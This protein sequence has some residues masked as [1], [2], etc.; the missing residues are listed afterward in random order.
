MAAGVAPAAANLANRRPAP[1][2]QPN[3]GPRRALAVPSRRPARPTIRDVAD[4]AGVALGSASRVINGHA[5]VGEDVRDKVLRAIAQLGYQPNSAA[6]SMRTRATGL[7]ACVVPDIQNPLYAAVLGAAE[8]AL[9]EA[10]Y[11]MLAA[12][13]GWSSERELKLIETFGRRRVDGV[14]AVTTDEGN[15]AL[16]AAYAA[17]GAPLVLLEREAP[18][19]LA[20][21]VASDQAQSLHAA[22]TMLLDLGHRRIALMTSPQHNRSGRERVTGYRAAFTE[23]DLPVDEDLVF[24]EAQTAEAAH[25]ATRA[26]LGRRHAPTAIITAGDRSLGGV[27][28]AI[29]ESGRRIPRDISVV[30]WGDGDLA[31]LVDPPITA[32]RYDANEIGTE[33]VRILLAVLKGDGA[34]PPGQRLLVP[35]E[36]ILRGSCAAP[37]GDAPS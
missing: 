18:I 29:R 32:I 23:R 2:G 27:L 24:G 16:H 11:T 31:Q 34:V 10:D 14:I 25:H 21:M 19:P 28:R 20:G 5:N 17:M 22:T 37:P 8:A 12:G 35:T 26:A 30:S 15:P 7:V 4:L 36:L 9:S 33:A 1:Y 3:R 6:Q 13:T